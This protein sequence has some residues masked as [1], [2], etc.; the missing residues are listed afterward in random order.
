MPPV[1]SWHVSG[2]CL[3]HLEEIALP[4]LLGDNR[5]EPSQ[6]AP[7]A[8]LQC[9]QSDRNLMQIQVMKVSCEGNP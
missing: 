8:H 7:L 5:M 6:A 4:G 3:T 2:G 9:K 1:S